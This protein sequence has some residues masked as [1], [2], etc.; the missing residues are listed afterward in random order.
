MNASV[1][2]LRKVWLESFVPKRVTY[3]KNDKFTVM[4]RCYA[5]GEY[6]N[7]W[8]AATG[9][10]GTGRGRKK[11]INIAP[12]PEN[13]FFGKAQMVWP[14]L[15]KP[16]KLGLQ[17]RK[18]K[19]DFETELKYDQSK[20]RGRLPGMNVRGWSGR[21][22]PGKHVGPPQTCNGETLED[23]DSIVIEVKRTAV[24]KKLGKKRTV[25]AVVVTGNGNGAIGWAIGKAQNPVAAIRKA[26]NKA[27]N[28]LHY[29]PICDNHTIF[30]NLRTKYEATKIIF[31]RR[32]A[33]HGLRCQRIIKAIAELAGIKDMRCK[34]VGSNTPQRIVKATFQGLKSQ[35]S[36][37]EL[38][39]RTG[40]NVV[41]YRPEMGLRPVVVA[42]PT[43]E[44]VQARLRR[45]IEKK[46]Q[47]I[48][49]FFDP[50]KGLHTAKPAR[51]L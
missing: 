33:G 10:R 42:S 44:A 49:A 1:H 13:L 26:R 8:A 27:A 28:Y 6:E 31:E 47:D 9:G 5:K 7:L 16:I 40:K 22:W 15:T 18:D 25:S 50:S 30:H 36:H 20:E 38:A 39:N 51:K 41:E 48:A 29:I 11:K 21:A 14:G 45:E 4:K 32:P 43:V 37:G 24:Q 19:D 3:Q 34:L 35:E 46:N 2:C 12:N 17:D 23:F